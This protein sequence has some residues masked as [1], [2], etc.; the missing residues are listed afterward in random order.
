MNIIIRLSRKY[1]S[2]L[3]QEYL[4]IMYPAFFATAYYGLFK[5]GEL[6][7][8][9]HTVKACDIYT[10]ENK[11]KMLFIL[12]SSKTHGA[13]SKPQTIKI[14]TTRIDKKSPS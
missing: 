4:R 7:K 5:I 9:D 3:G 1:F 8:G 2:D 13:E 11:D 10:G 12:R 14:S 6:A